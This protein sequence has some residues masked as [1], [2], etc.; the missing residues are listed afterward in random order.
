MDLLRDR[1]VHFSALAGFLYGLFSRLAFSLKW[2][3]NIWPS[4]HGAGT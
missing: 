4:E 1:T 3:Q 2:P